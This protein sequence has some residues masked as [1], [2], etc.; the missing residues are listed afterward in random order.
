LTWTKN[1]DSFLDL[2]KH[3]HDIGTRTKAQLLDMI[4]QMVLMSPQCL[5]VLGVHGFEEPKEGEAY[6]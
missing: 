2:E 3:L 6:F 5:G 1:P 4:R